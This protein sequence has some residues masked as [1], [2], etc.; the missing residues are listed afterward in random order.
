VCVCECVCED[1]H[2]VCSF[3]VQAKDTQFPKL[4][5]LD[6]S[7]MGSQPI[8]TLYPKVQFDEGPCPLI[9]LLYHRARV[10][11]EQPLAGRFTVG[12]G[13]SGQKLR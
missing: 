13:C 5:E 9:Q 3:G 1:M 2:D 7:M 8:I 6:Y 4:L 10:M 12:D 11:P